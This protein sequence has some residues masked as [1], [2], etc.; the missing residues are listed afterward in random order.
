[1]QGRRADWELAEYDADLRTL[2]KRA[3]GIS[4]DAKRDLVT[5]RGIG[6]L[7]KVHASDIFTDADCGSILETKDYVDHP[8][9]RLYQDNEATPV[10]DLMQQKN[11]IFA[12]ARKRDVETDLDWR[13]P[14]FESGQ[15]LLAFDGVALLMLEMA[16]RRNNRTEN[17]A[18]KR[19]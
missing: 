14:V 3:V 4:W 6:K 19:E 15:Y 16:R 8:A 12:L 18:E 1:V 7:R 10:S 11:H 9:L 13:L 2:L 17:S 5:I